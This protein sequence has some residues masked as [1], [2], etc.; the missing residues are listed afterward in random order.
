[1]PYSCQYCDSDKLR[2]RA[3]DAL[4]LA[5]ELDKENKRLKSLNA[6]CRCSTE[7]TAT[8]ARE[9]KSLREQVATLILLLRARP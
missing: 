7:A 8:L 1:M 2:M 6:E 4:K 5:A 3:D 9:N